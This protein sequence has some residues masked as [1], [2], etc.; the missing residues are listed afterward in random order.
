VT[1]DAASATRLPSD[2]R[3]FAFGPKSLPKG[4]RSSRITRNSLEPL[5]IVQEPK[6]LVSWLI[7]LEFPVERFRF[8]ERLLFYRQRG[9]QIDSSCV[10][11]L[12]A[13]P[14]GD[15]RAV[16][17]LLQKVHGHGV[18]QAVDGYAFAFQ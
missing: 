10:E 16:H 7:P 1:G 2:W 17:T 6:E 11:G 12:V 15:D 5:E 3:P 13:E 18:P 14:Q 4:W 8:A 9:L